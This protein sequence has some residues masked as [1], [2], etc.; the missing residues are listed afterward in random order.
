LCY[1][2]RRRFYLEREEKRREDKRREEKCDVIMWGFI[3]RE[4]K[5]WIRLDSERKGEG[6][7]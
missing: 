5:D 6:G 1:L 4:M 7:G 2:N 3:Y